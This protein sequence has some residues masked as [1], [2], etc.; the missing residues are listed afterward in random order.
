M[1]RE[2][3]AGSFLQAFRK[4]VG[5]GQKAPPA[6]MAQGMQQ[7]PNAV[8]ETYN[9]RIELSTPVTDVEPVNDGYRLETPAGNE[10]F[11]HVVCTTPAS[12]TADLLDG[13]AT[14][15]DDLGSLRYNPLALVYLDADL[16]QEGFGYQVGYG[17]DLHTL[18]A[19]WN[20]SMFDRDGVHTIFLGGMHDPEL[21]EAG[22]DRLAEV[23]R[24]EFEIVT[25]A[26]SSV[27][28]IARLDPGFPAWDQSWWALEDVETPEG[29]DLATNYTARMGI[30]S[31]VREARELAESVSDR[32]DDTAP[33]TASTD[34]ATA[35]ASDD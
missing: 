10:L 26:S 19:S 9:D 11:D 8:A 15:V 33:L 25:G 21:L 17:E 24:E 35:A 16:D 6:S 14:G 32:A 31:R 29:I 20:A 7:L 1:E 23:A 3:K 4:R 34:S 30:P 12:V 5:Q 2:Q 18:G 22:D 28:D 13:I 27:I